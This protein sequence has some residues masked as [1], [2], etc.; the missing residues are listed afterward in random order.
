MSKKQNT[1][2]WLIIT[3]FVIISL[4]L[5][6]QFFSN[7]EKYEIAG[8]IKN[9]TAISFDS[10]TINMG[11]LIFNQPKEAVFSFT[12]TGEFPLIIHTVRAS[13]GCT[14][15]VWPKKTVKPGKAGTI[16]VIYNASDIGHFHKSINVIANTRPNPITLKIYGDV[17]KE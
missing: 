6:L 7:N 2:F 14:L 9:S 10:K 13:C 11:S 1:L 4:F 8:G 15:P 17:K 5:L 16:R 12:N 3:A